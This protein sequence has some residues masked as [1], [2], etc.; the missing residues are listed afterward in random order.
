MGSRAAIMR[1]G[2]TE[3]S[4]R[5][6]ENM[7]SSMPQKA[8]SCS[9]YCRRGDGQMITL[10][11]D[12]ASREAKRRRTDEMHNDLAVGVGLEGTGSLEGLAEG[13]VV[14]DL[15]V[16]GKGEGLILAGERLSSSVCKSKR[17]R[18]QLR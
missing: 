16:D 11:R 2:V 14:V 1:E 18:D 10:A 3:S 13:A 17:S 8:V 4:T 5:T 15:S 6:N 7:P 12:F 9:L